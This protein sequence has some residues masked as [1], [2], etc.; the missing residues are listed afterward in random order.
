MCEHENT[1]V[2]THEQSGET[3]VGIGAE[4]CDDCGDVVEI[5]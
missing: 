5:L 2:E 3:P 1:T 4:L